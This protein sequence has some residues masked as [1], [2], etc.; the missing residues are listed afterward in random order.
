MHVLSLNSFKIQT[1]VYPQKAL[2]IHFSAVSYLIN[3]SWW[4]NKELWYALSCLWDG[5]HKTSLAAN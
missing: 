1:E 5:T 2:S 4:T 3:P